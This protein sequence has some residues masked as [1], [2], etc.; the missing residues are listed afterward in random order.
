MKIKLFPILFL[1]LYA[2][3]MQVKEK[4]ANELTIDPST[5]TYNNP[6]VERILV[7]Q[8]TDYLNAFATGN[9]DSA[10]FYMYHGIFD[11]MK[12]E[13]ADEYTSDAINKIITEPIIKLKNMQAERNVK[14]SFEIGEITRRVEWE[15]HLLY[16]IVTRVKMKKEFDE[17]VTGD[18]IVAISNDKGTNWKFIQLDKE[19][20]PQILDLE[21][22]KNIISQ[23]IKQTITIRAL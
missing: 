1:L 12:K 5:T 8:L 20:T 19:T 6:D 22:P 2:C 21:Y 17:I 15:E 13:F 4:N 3:S 14:I 10:I 9:V 11:F 23:V 18:E 16:T 7:A